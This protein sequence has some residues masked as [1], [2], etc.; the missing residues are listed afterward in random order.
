MPAGARAGGAR[1]DGAGMAFDARLVGMNALERERC[2]VVERPLRPGR[3][4]HLVATLTCGRKARDRMVRLRRRLVVGLVAGDARRTQAGVD[5]VRVA[6]GAA[7]GDVRALQRPRGVSV[8]AGAPA[9][10]AGLV[11]RLADRRESGRGVRGVGRLLV[12]LLVAAGALP[13][14]TREDPAAMACLARLCRVG[15]D[16]LEGGGMLERAAGPGGVAGRVAQ[17]AVGGEAA[18]HMRRRGGGLEVATMTGDAIG[19]RRPDED[20]AG[21]ARLAFEPAVGGIEREAGLG[22]MAP[23]G[24]RPG[25]R[26][27]AALALVAEPGFEAVVVLANPVA[28]EAAGGRVRRVGVGVA[29]G[30]RHASMRTL[31]G[32]GGR[33]VKSARRR[34]PFGRAVTRL[35]GSAESA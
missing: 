24:A 31:Q 15:A 23:L 2:G 4:R 5:V 10:V 25:R 26:V 8:P 30:A 32:E 22:G 6:G 29:G 7:W 11:A 19:R 13:R 35:A 1:E 27:V 34:A 20:A 28:V 16:Q 18:T 17:G 14:G 3:M 21:V 9:R 33:L 12:L